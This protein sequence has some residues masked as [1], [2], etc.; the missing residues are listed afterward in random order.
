H[1]STIVEL[2]LAFEASIVNLRIFANAKRNKATEKTKKR[3]PEDRLNHWASHQMAIVSPNV[4]MCQ[5]LKEKIKSAI[6]MSSCAI[7]P[8][9]TELEV[10][11][12]QSKK[13]MELTKGQIA[14]WI[15][16]PD[17]LRRIVFRSTSLR[18]EVANA[19][20]PLC[21]WLARERGFETK[22]TDLML[23]RV[24]SKPFFTHSARESEWTKVKA[25]LNC[26]LL[27]FERNQF[28]SG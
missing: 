24:N 1:L 7:S 22:I 27:V 3:R 17:L 26:C 8:K 4:P 23:E 16:D 2:E 20:L 12:V 10:A 14:E 28:D 25:S 11:E 19:T 9:V 21:F 15:G 6:K 5:A 13:T 18:A